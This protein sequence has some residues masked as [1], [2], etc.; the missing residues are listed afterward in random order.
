MQRKNSRMEFVALV[1]FLSCLILLLTNGFAPRLAAQGDEVDVYQK[2]EP[3]GDVLDKILDEYVLEADMDRVV[4]GA[5]IGMMGS[6][7]RHSSF[8]TAKDLEDM[9]QETKGEFFGI[10]VSIKLDENRQIMVFAPIPGSPA[11]QAGVKPYDLIIGVDDIPTEGMSTQEVA[12]KIKGPK[13]TPVKLTLSRKQ[14]DK[15]LE[16]EVLDVTVKRDRVPLESVKEARLLDNGIGYMRISDFKENTAGDMKKHLKEFLDQGMT[17]FILDLRWNPGGLLNSS[18]DVSEL[19]LPKNSLVTFTKGRTQPDGSSNPSDM[20]LFTEA[21]PVIPEG[22]PI[23]V[24]VNETTASSSEI[25][26]GALQFYERA[27]ILGEKTFGKGSVQT[28]IPLAHPQMTALR[29]TTALYY[30]PAE[31]TINHQGILPDIDEPM[32]STDEESL[33]IQLHTSAAVDPELVNQQ[34]H[35]VVTGNELGEDVVDD[36]QFARAVGILEEDTV[37]ENLIKK[38]HRDV[39]ETQMA[40]ETAKAAEDA[41]TDLVIN[42]EPGADLIL[43]EAE[44]SPGV[45]K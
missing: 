35:G 40:E 17:G 9:R 34:N 10:G 41:P 18:K 3:I 16:P 30:T 6:L 37:W 29:L 23:I 2:I 27:L 14:E 19:F 31:V 7:D 22:F 39:H 25:V 4:E 28:I 12:E 8:I 33:Y 15:T 36:V 43:D 32:S 5:L 11:E 44:T 1:T 26:T 13:G 42:D 24:L 20:R 45:D 21:N 38:Y